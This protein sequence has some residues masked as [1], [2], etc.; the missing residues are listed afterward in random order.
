MLVEV[1]CVFTLV[2]V[3]LG[4][5]WRGQIKEGIRSINPQTMIIQTDN[6]KE[7]TNPTNRKVTLFEKIVKEKYQATHFLIPYRRPTWNSD[8]ESFHNL[9]EEEFFILRKTE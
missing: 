2:E 6:G 7:F 1:I 5:V 8:V 9:I 3:F 4:K